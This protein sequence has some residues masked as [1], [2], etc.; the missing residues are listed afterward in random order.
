MTT[1]FSSAHRL[2]WRG[3]SNELHQQEA[4]RAT[5]HTLN[6]TTHLTPRIFFSRGS[7][8]LRRIARETMESRPIRP[9]DEAREGP[10]RCE[11]ASQGDRE[12][13]YLIR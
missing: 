6:V 9:T 5:A 10:G 1:K 2:A 7:K 13:G 4:V 11:V 12:G 8:E 3:S